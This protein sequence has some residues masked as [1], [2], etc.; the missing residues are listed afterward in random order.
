MS[1]RSLRT[2]KHGTLKPNALT[3][4]SPAD[5]QRR[6]I[7][8]MPAIARQREVSGDADDAT[9]DT[10]HT[11]V[12][13]LPPRAT[14]RPART[15]PTTAGMPT[16]ESSAATE[17]RQM[18]VWEEREDEL[19]V[20]VIA[21]WVAA[22]TRNPRATGD[23]SA[24]QQTS[25]DAATHRIAASRHGID[26]ADRHRALMRLRTRDDLHLIQ[27][28]RPAVV[29]LIM[30]HPF[31]SEEADSRLIALGIR[32]GVWSLPRTAD[33]EFDPYR[34][35]TA[36]RISSFVRDA[37]RHLST[38]SKGSYASALRRLAAGPV[39]PDRGER[40]TAV[41]PHTAVVEDGLWSA[42]ESFQIDSWRHG[43]AKT[44]LA[45][46][47]GAGAM[48]AEIN[49]L[50]P[51]DVL[52]DETGPSVRVSLRLTRDRTWEVRDVPVVEPRYAEWLVGRARQF[53]GHTY[54]FK[55][56]VIERRNAINSTRRA[57]ARANAAFERFDLPAA[58]NA[59]AA[60]WLSVGLPF[61]VWAKAA[62]IAS[63]THLPTDLLAFL[64]TPTPD[65]I[66]TA[67]RRAAL[68]TRPQ[69]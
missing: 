41:E 20:E 7:R 66:E 23:D 21:G 37:G 63:G 16:R 46:T 5:I 62:G 33:G 39:N 42:A 58:R 38:G 3:P 9:A 29:N 18:T 55:P 6:Q 48:P 27:R 57:L 64:P 25:D 44:L 50:A 43:E 65:D 49:R 69:S 52:I 45:T 2:S 47:F 60:R 67:F 19:E 28:V 12:L 26:P 68:R 53:A 14:A 10:S 22:T 59:W 54:L 40:R 1:R 30:E 61:E 4:L 51:E 8:A 17:P 13:P 32:F 31:V 36:D 34:D 24:D 35:L 15:A 56:D 11:A